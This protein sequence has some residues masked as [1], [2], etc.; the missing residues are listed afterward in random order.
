[1]KK[2]IK[3][4]RPP[5]ERLAAQLQKMFDQA[6]SKG[7]EGAA[8]KQNNQQLNKQNNGRLTTTNI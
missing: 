5:D 4:K 8:T 3:V 2:H 6:T 1:M 7:A